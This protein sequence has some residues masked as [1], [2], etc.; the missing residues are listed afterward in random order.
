[1]IQLEIYGRPV[2]CN[3]TK[4]TNRNNSN[5]YFN[6]KQKQI[7]QAKWQLKA[8]FN[9]PIIKGPV[10]IKVHY[11][12]HIPKS[13]SFIKRKQMLANIIKHDKYPDTD[14]CTNFLK[15]CLKKVV[16]EDDKLIWHEDCYKYWCN[17]EKD[18]KTLIYLYQ[19]K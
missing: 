13:T 10:E 4:Y 12:F 2:T 1:M 14:R 7:D 6:P 9:R 17:S 16:V 3:S 19:D 8:Q 5:H 18:E 15:D 11:F